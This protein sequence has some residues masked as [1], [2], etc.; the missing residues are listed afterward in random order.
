MLIKNQPGRIQQKGFSLIELIVGM[1]ILSLMVA[2]LIPILTQSEIY[3][4]GVDKR[5]KASAYATSIIETVKARADEIA[6]DTPYN[7]TSLA[8]DEFEFALI[9]DYSV[10]IPSGLDIKSTE[11]EIKHYDDKYSDRM[12]VVNVTVTWLDNSREQSYELSTIIT[13]PLN[14]EDAEN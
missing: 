9:N 14:E 11:L 8:T 10:K 2:S 4:I 3:L 5:L 1:V 6:I 12:A 13:V 7:H